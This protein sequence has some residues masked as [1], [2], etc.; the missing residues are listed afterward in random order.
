M[1]GSK[2]EGGESIVGARKG[3]KGE[4]ERKKDRN[5]EGNEGNWEER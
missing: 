5:R 2:R 4:R 1:K 3:N